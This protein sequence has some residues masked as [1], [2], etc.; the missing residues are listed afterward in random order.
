VLSVQLEQ[1]FSELFVEGVEAVEVVC[2]L[3]ETLAG[4]DPPSD[5]ED[6]LSDGALSG[7]FETP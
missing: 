3:F 6:V 4:L 1:L 5:G 2:S 7:L